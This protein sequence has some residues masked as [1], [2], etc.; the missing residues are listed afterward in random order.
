MFLNFID[1]MILKIIFFKK[2]ILKNNYY[3]T[4]KYP[5][6]IYFSYEFVASSILI[7]DDWTPCLSW[8]NLIN[9]FDA[10]ADRV[11]LGKKITM[12]LGLERITMKSTL[13]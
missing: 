2:N 9:G 5:L 8:I 11:G 13:K 6:N 12:K 3:H 1:V 4:F 10:R 7:V